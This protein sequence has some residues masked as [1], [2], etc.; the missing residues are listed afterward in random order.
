MT[1]SNHQKK[2]IMAVN[3][4]KNFGK[5]IKSLA[6]GKAAEIIAPEANALTEKIRA[7]TPTLTGETRKSITSRQHS[8]WGHTIS[9]PLEK[10]RHI[11]FGTE[12]TP[13]FA[14]FR[15]TFDQNAD[16]IAR[17]LEKKFKSHIESIAST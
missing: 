2:K 13:R 8:K 5:V 15:K 10:A 7:A 9:T 6:S 11:E 1:F 3:Y 4:K 16:I 17:S 14:M 12:D